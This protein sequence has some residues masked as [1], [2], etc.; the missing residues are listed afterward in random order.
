MQKERSLEMKEENAR[1]A[2]L[3]DGAR[4][5]YLASRAR[6]SKCEEVAKKGN[7]GKGYVVPTYAPAKAFA[8]LK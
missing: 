5:V 1:K 7:R 6:L 3:S 4:A 2:K 8:R